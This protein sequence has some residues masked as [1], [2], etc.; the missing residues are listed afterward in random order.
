MATIDSIPELKT[1]THINTGGLVLRVGLVKG[2]GL[3]FGIL[4]PAGQRGMK[5]SSNPQEKPRY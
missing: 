1:I 2:L 4:L 3:D 5:K